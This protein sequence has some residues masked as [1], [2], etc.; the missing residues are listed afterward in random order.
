MQWAELTLEVGAL[1][2]GI[3]EIRGYSR[4]PPW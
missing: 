3:D 2:A 1:I 4:S